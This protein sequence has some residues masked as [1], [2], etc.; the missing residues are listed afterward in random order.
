[1]ALLLK[2]CVDQKQDCASFDVFDETGIFHVVN[3]PTGW[4][5]PNPD[6]AN[7]TAAVV[8]VLIPDAT[9]PISINV[10]PTL[11]NITNTP[12]NVTLALLGLGSLTKLPDGIYTVEYVVTLNVAPFIIAQTTTVLFTCQAKCCIDKLLASLTDKN[13]SCEDDKAKRALQAYTML[14]AAQKAAC[15]GHIENAKKLLKKAQDLCNGN[16]AAC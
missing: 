11:P 6:I 3:N 12:F 13:C 2:E 5:A 16:C 7:A 9:V 1:M 8:N 4:G 10:F 15:C 14:I